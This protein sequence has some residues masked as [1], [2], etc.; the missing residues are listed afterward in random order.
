MATKN[1]KTVGPYYYYYYY[2]TFHA[3]IVAQIALYNKRITT[4]KAYSASETL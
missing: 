2:C 3:N 4:G 1:S